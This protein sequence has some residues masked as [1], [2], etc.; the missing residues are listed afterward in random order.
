MGINGSESDNLSYHEQADIPTTSPLS[1]KLAKELK[2][3]GFKFI[4][5]TTLYA[6]LEAVGIINDHVDGCF[7]K[8]EVA[9]KE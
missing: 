2:K 4:G 8:Q 9:C 3:R 7:R 6:F 5:S 1:D